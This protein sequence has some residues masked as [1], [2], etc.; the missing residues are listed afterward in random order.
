M[1]RRGS[2]DAHGAVAT[3]HTLHLNEGA[4]LVS[5]VREANKAVS[6]RLASVGI[7]HD[8]GTLAGREAGLEQRD[9][10]E[11]SDLRAK[12]ANED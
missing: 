9:Q 6:A 12:I 11:F 3:V 5:L 8:L 2:A 10:N 1:L 7:G 4:L